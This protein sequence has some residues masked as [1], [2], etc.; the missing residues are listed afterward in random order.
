MRNTVV[1]MLMAFA[2]CI[3]CTAATKAPI[4]APCN[5]SPLAQT[6]GKADC[7]LCRRLLLGNAIG[8]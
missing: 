7:G 5:D 6:S 3:G 1:A 2:A 8:V 4:P